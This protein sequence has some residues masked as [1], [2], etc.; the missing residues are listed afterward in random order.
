[1]AD[2]SRPDTVRRPGSVPEWPKGAVCKTAAKATL[3]RIQPGPL[4]PP[5]GGP[6]IFS[7]LVRGSRVRTTDSRRSAAILVP[8]PGR[9]L[10]RGPRGLCASLLLARGCRWPRGAAPA[11]ATTTSRA[12]RTRTYF[13]VPER[14]KL[15]DE[16]S[17]LD[18]S[19][20]DLSQGRDRGAARDHVDTV[21]DGDPAPSLDARGDQA[22]ELP[23]RAGHRAG[24]LS[25]EAA[26]GVSLQS[27]R[28]LF[29]DIDGALEDGARRA[30]GSTSRWSSTVG[31]TVRTWSREPQQRRTAHAHRQPDR[32][33][34]PGDDQGVRAQ[35]LRARPS[36]TTRTSRRS[37]RSSTRGR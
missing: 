12:A 24:P 33:A 6:L 18:A 1:M 3:V 17:L 8:M 35:R 4:G 28:N 34:R 9:R 22:A 32:A 7:Q 27:L 2:G 25:P 21:F 23:G 37:T 20:A 36:A 15:Y 10:A 30:S 26:D 13:K 11:A 14:W 5:F 29:F 31:S 16:E 19:K